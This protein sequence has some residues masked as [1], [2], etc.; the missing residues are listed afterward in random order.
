MG[1]YQFTQ[2][3]DSVELLSTFQLFYHNHGRLP[4]ING[5]LI[6]PGSD[7]SEREEKINLKNLYEMF[8]Y[9]KSH[10]LVSIQFL[11]VLSLFFGA[12]TRESKNA[13]TE[14]YKNLSYA[15]LSG[16]DNFN[17]DAVSNLI[18]SLCCSI[19]KITLANRDRREVEDAKNAKEIINTTTFV[20]LPDPFEQEIIDDQFEDLK[21]KKT[22][23]P[24]VKPQ[25]TQTT[26]TEPQTIDNEFSKL[27]QKFD[28]VNNA[29]TE[30]KLQNAAIN[31]IDDILDEDNPF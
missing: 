27:K 4:L 21:H 26:E 31:L 12:G 18:S 11:G 30:Q 19:K 7:V 10:G 23:H 2:I 20:P 14:L 17:F 22:R 3:D 16:A 24:Y 15:T 25:V 5:L 13:I 6:F 8:R 29:V 28:K 9:T 1:I